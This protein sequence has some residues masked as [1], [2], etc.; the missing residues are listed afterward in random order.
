VQA[1]G[2]FFHYIEQ[3]RLMGR[4]IGYMDAHLLL[5]PAIHATLLWTRDNRLKK[6]SA[7]LGLTYPA[8]KG[9][10]REM[11]RRPMRR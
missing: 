4:G 7:E 6:G 2:E 10:F 11:R 1:K 9:R 8:D 5:A 3:Y